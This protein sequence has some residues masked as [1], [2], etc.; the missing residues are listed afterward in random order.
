MR[1][2]CIRTWMVRVQCGLHIFRC[3]KDIG[4]SE[5]EG[6]WDWTAKFWSYYLYIFIR[7]GAVA[8]ASIGKPSN[9]NNDEVWW[10]KFCHNNAF[11]SVCVGL[12]NLPDVLAIVI[13]PRAFEL[14]P[15]CELRSFDSEC[16]HASHCATEPLP[17]ENFTF[18]FSLGWLPGG[19]GLAWVVVAR[20]GRA[21]LQPS[22]HVLQPVRGP[23]SGSL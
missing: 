22:R 8:R 19:W 3:T 6:P 23:M 17:P 13:D 16:W 11:R 7:G 10:S 14:R 4:L 5:F 1:V 18:L 2:R 12:R 9:Q 15:G 20:K 21:T